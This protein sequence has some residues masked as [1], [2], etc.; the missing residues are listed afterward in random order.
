M[1]GVH[2]WDWI[3]ESVVGLIGR[4]GDLADGTII[5]VPFDVSGHVRKVITKSN[6]HVCSSVT[7]VSC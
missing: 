1:E 3:Q 5:T 4:F 7:R 2:R 6:S